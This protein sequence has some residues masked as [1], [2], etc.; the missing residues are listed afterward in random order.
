MQDADVVIEARNLTQRFGAVT[1]VDHAAAPG[2][3]DRAPLVDAPP[4]AR[5]PCLAARARDEVGGG[6]WEVG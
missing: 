4:T 2:P 6:F 5:R 3:G 1:A